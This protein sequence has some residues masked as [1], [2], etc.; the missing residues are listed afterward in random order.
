MMFDLMLAVG[1]SGQFLLGWGVFPLVGK[2]PDST[3]DHVE[4]AGVLLAE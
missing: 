4:Q 2:L 1:K 3:G